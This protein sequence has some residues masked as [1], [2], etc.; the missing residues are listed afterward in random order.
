MD[1]IS[2]V[3]AKRYSRLFRSRKMLS[4]FNYKQ[5]NMQPT[6]NNCKL[7]L[8]KKTI[9]LITGTP[10]DV[11]NHLLSGPTTLLRDILSLAV[12]CIRPIFFLE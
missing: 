1:Y 10:A 9:A 2:G 5:I 4:L 12:V 6:N 7:K 3:L 11:R 8:E